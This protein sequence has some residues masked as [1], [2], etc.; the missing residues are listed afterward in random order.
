MTPLRHGEDHTPTRL[1]LDRSR[2]SNV[3]TPIDRA[4]ESLEKINGVFRS[5]SVGTFDAIS[6]IKKPAKSDIDGCYIFC[7]FVNAFRPE[8][9]Q[10]DSFS[11][12]TWQSMQSFM[13]YS[14]NCQK[15]C[16]EVQQ[17]KKK[18]LRPH[19][20]RVQNHTYDQLADLRAT[21]M[22]N[23]NERNLNV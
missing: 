8:A 23:L 18:V 20:C 2:Y 6:L 7:R 3:T 17:I 16:L 14:P 19:I 13:L 12:Q 22:G 10:W 21:F 5:L 9:E 15:I 4:S 11:L 1:A